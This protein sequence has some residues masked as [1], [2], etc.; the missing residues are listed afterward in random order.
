[1]REPCPSIRP[2]DNSFI[3]NCTYFVFI[4]QKKKK[5]FV[6]FDK[7]FLSEKGHLFLI[8]L[9]VNILKLDFKDCAR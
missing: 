1:M 8:P 9:I 4:L 5:F 3:V 2:T 6:L 7:K